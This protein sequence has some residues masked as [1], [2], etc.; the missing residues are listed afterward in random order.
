MEKVDSATEEAVQEL[1]MVQEDTREAF[2][3]LMGIGLAAERFTHEFDR[4]TSALDSN[5]RNLEKM[6][7]LESPTK[8]LRR[9]AEVLK[10]EISLISVARYVRKEQ[11]NPKTSV[12]TVIGLTFNAHEDDIEADKIQVEYNAEADFM[13]EISAASLSQIVDN[14]VANAIYWLEAKTEVGDRKLSVEV[15]T[16]ELTIIIS[17]NGAAIAH[18]I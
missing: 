6:H 4:L 10:N 16:K 12:K 18:N 13:V 5:L 3:H 15:V 11:A 2:L 9:I 7:P 1:L 8:A 14:V 17:D